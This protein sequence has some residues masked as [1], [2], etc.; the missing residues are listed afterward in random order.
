[1]LKNVFLNNEYFRKYK[2]ISVFLLLTRNLKRLRKRSEYLH[3]FLLKTKANKKLLSYSFLPPF[4][5]KYSE[6]RNLPCKQFVEDADQ[7]LCGALIGQGCEPANVGKQD[8]A[9]ENKI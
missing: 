5:S 2:L 1:M 6:N 9:T 4:Q 8:T 7:L 3:N